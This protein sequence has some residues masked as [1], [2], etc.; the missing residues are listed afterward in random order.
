MENAAKALLMAAGMLMAVL[1]ASMFALL[2]STMSDYAQQ[3]E[4][5]RQAQKV[6]QFNAQFMQYMKQGGSSAQ[7]IVSVYNLAK[8]Y[9]EQGITV[10]V[11]ID[12]TEL[13]KSDDTPFPGGLNGIKAEEFITAHINVGNPPGTNQYQIDNFD[14]NPEYDNGR[15]YK[16]K[17]RSNGQKTLY[18][19]PKKKNK[20]ILQTVDKNSIMKKESI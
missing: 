12:T 8:Y 6:Q 2:F 17:F 16:I 11:Y 4:D 15:I 14:A 5:T 18:K 13:V 3:Y 10:S 19:K 9:Q 20:K 7:D 1:V